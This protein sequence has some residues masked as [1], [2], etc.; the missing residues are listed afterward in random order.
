[1][2]GMT[3]IPNRSEASTSVSVVLD[4][5]IFDAIDG[6]PRTLAHVNLIGGLSPPRFSNFL[7]LGATVGRNLQARGSIVQVETPRVVGKFHGNVG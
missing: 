7:R 4:L 6:K 5:E 1:M 2:K 3:A